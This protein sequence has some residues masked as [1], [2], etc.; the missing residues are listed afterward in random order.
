MDG[1][2]TELDIVNLLGWE[3]KAPYQTERFTF[4]GYPEIDFMSSTE[5]YCTEFEIK[6]SW[7][8]YKADKKKIYK[9]MRLSDMF[10]NK[11]LK[12]FTPN[13]F[14][15]VV[16]LDI[17]K[18]VLNDLPIYCGVMAFAVYE[19]KLVLV[20]GSKFDSK[21]IHKTAVDEKFFKAL[22]KHLTFKGHC[23]SVFENEHKKKT[24]KLRF[25]KYEYMNRT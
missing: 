14:V 21:F 13:K 8:D 17:L 10:L 24:G 25:S 7:E 11:N 12:G 22:A 3:I 19:N 20:P 5:K 23:N 6:L 2:I 16:P 4:D 15:Y 1:K 18:K 9:H